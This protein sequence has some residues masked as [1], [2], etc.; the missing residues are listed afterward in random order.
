MKILVVSNYY[1]PFEIGGW[2]QL[3]CDVAGELA[4]R[5]H[6]LQVLTSN[7]KAEAVSRPEP[8]IARQL[9]LQS[10][11]PFHY[12]A[13]SSL[14]AG[15]RDRQNRAVLDHW[16]TRFQPDIVFINGL[17][18]LSPRLAE[19]AEEM[20]GRRIIYYMAS[21]WPLEAD[22]HTIFWDDP[23][24]RTWRRWPK[25][26]L[27]ALVRPLFL[28]PFPAKQLAFR[29]VLCVSRY[30]Q[31][32]MIE[33][34]GVPPANTQVVYNGIEPE[35]FGAKLV[36][37]QSSMVIRLLYAGQIRADKGLHTAI[38]ALAQALPHHPNLSLT[39][40]GGGA[41]GYISQLKERVQQLGLESVVTFGRQVGREAMPAIFAEHDVLLFPSIWPEPLARVV[42]EAMA[43]GLVVI[44]TTTG[45]TPE[46][47]QNDHNGLTFAAENATQLAEKIGQIASNPNLAATLARNSRQT[48][49]AHFTLTRM[50]D[51]LEQIFVDLTN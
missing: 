50:A 25:K 43:C 12:R 3:T 31:Q 21:P 39:I 40:V 46:L 28:R 51:Q 29:R 20:A 37:R 11:D 10:P 2:E 49:L 36:N 17:W 34:V 38:E 48:I 1:P 42:Q 47:L 27:G 24:G 9:H 23:A 45:G 44:G 4:R 13:R 15:R 16:L 8:T 30:I 22:A 18:N 26:W 35:L 33:Q 14:L 19:A 5:G 7:H 32:M 41:P 6:Q